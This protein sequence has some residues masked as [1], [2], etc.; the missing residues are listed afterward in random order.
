[1]HIKRSWCWVSASERPGLPAGDCQAQTSHPAIAAKAHQTA[2]PA[3]TACI[4]LCPADL[5]LAVML[6]PAAMTPAPIPAPA[7]VRA[8]R[9]HHQ[10]R[11]HHR[12]DD[13][14]YRSG[15]R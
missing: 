6:F 14:L 10:R 3:T 4:W 13:D 9:H 7:G 8:G 2:A 11:R 1:M 5:L 15:A 12:L